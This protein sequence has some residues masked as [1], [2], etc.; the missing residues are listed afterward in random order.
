M[1]NKT[2][3]MVMSR[4]VVLVMF[5]V[6]QKPIDRWLLTGKLVQGAV[7]LP[8][9]TTIQSILHELYLQECLGKNPQ[10]ANPFFF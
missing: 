4:G 10:G 9:Y 6:G 3:L 5:Q 1:L 2:K 7:N 8:N